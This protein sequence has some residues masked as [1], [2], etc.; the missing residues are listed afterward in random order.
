VTSVA[1][2]AALF[3]RSERP[4]PAAPAV[5]AA[6][7]VI[8]LGAEAVCAGAAIALLGAARAGAA[9]LLVVLGGEAAPA[10]ALAATRRARRLAARLSARELPALAVGRL[11]C[12]RCPD[13]AT[14]RRALAAGGE[15]SCVLAV[16]VPRDDEL[17]TLLAG[18]IALVAGA[19]DQDPGLAQLA[20]STLPAGSVAATLTISGLE[21]ALATQ[22]WLAGRGLRAALGPALEAQPCA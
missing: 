6:A 15:G 5:T 10:P 9:P 12:V 18:A 13:L 2:L 7:P 20:L 1:R 14:A 22:G 8:V 19:A 11:V 16:A 4:A 3:V 17:D 21:R